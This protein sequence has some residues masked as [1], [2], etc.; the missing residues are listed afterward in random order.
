MKA[1]ALTNHITS[2]S[3]PGA[4]KTSDPFGIQKKTVPLVFCLTYT[5]VALVI[6]HWKERLKFGSHN[7]NKTNNDIPKTNPR[8]CFVVHRDKRVS[9]T[10]RAHQT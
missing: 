4:T 10:T 5:R 7:L 3:F 9:M 6:I 1:T 8:N 2:V